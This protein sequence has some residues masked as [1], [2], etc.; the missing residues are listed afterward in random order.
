MNQESISPYQLKQF[1]KHL[2]LV[3]KHYH[4]RDIA[5]GLV[6]SDLEKINASKKEI[7]KLRANI[8]SL[9]R[10]HED[11]SL[12]GKTR[13]MYPEHLARMNVM[14]A[15]MER[16]ERENS[17]L[18]S[19]NRRVHDLID[20]IIS[21]HK[22]VRRTK[23]TVDEKVRSIEKNVNRSFRDIIKKEL[24]HQILVTEREYKRLAGSKTV[25]PARMENILERLKES[26][27]RLRSIK[28]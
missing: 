20:E 8:A 15:R 28:S 7:G 22:T 13:K 23:T 27:K 11:V 17:H 3:S 5:H 19:E 4:A 6:Q 14:G 24:T 2:C 16:L 10:T 18:R 12:L 21:A 1:L 26:K 25:H 9:M